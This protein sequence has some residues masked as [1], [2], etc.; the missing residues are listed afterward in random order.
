M[1]KKKYRGLKPEEVSELFQRNV[2]SQANRY[3]R[4][5][6]MKTPGEAP[7][8]VVV[9]PRKINVSAVL[10]NRLKRKISELIR[11][12]FSDWTGGRRVAIVLKASAADASSKL[13]RESFCELMRKAGF[14]H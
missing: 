14:F 12:Q 8:F 2:L 5:N 6:W 1:L 3:F 7:Q 10:R 9:I 11:T 4:V 13:F